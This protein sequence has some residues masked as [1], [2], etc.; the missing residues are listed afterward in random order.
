MMLIYSL[1]VN[2]LLEIHWR[3][4]VGR[5]ICMANLADESYNPTVMD[6]MMWQVGPDEDYN[7]PNQTSAMGNDGKHCH[8]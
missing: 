2:R 5:D 3:L 8:E 1:G 4:V 7:P 6:S